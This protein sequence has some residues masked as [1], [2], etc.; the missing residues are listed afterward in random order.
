[1]SCFYFE[2]LTNYAVIYDKYMHETTNQRNAIIMPK[3]CQ[4]EGFNM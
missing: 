3:K 2:L 4:K 1:M